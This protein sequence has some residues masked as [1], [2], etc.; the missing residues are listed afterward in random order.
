MKLIRSGG[1]NHSE[2][3][4]ILCNFLVPV[5]TYIKKGDQHLAEASS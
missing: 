3:F 1:V 5:P 2:S 4:N